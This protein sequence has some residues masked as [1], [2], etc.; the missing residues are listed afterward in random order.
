MFGKLVIALIL[1]TALIACSVSSDPRQGGLLG[2]LRG[3]STGTYDAR[4]QQRQAELDHQQDI[5][6]ELKEQADNLENEAKAKDIAL[7]SEQQILSE[8]ENDLS[9]L[10]SDLN[11][12]NSESEQQKSDIAA[13]NRKIED[14]RRR[15]KSQQSALMKLDRAGGSA[16]DPDRYKILM[17]ERDKLAAEYKSLLKYYQALSNA[18]R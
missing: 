16:A 10:K 14:F 7:A 3:L 2:G 4:V 12:L 18:A 1:T 5:S 15:L 17:R 6:Q 8:I 13:Q 11:R 9:N